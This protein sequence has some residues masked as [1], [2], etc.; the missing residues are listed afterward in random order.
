MRINLNSLHMAVVKQTVP[1]SPRGIIPKFATCRKA[2]IQ[3]NGAGKSETTVQRRDNWNDGEIR[4][5][6]DM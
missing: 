5:L 2:T 3:Q 1:A 6:V 4:V